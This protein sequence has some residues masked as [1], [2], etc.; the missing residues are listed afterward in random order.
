MFE[1]GISIDHLECNYKTKTLVN[2]IPGFLE[3]PKCIGIEGLNNVCF[4]RGGYG[5]PAAVDTLETVLALGVKKIVLVGMCGVFHE[6]IE[7]GDVIVPK[8]ILREEGTSHHY[9]GSGLLAQPDKNMLCSIT[10]FM[11]RN[12]TVYNERTVSTDAVY[13][14]TFRKEQ[15]WREVGV[16][17]VDME[18]S[19]VLAVCNYYKVP[20]VAILLASDKHP[21]D[22]TEREWQ[23]G[24]KGFKEKRIIFLDDIIDYVKY[25]A[26]TELIDG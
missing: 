6:R 7:V 12:F 10:K 15:S 3:T 9:I 25:L 1:I 18:A 14:Q 20:A 21:L 13:R 22:A 24:S 23:W 8:E 11:K 19:A 2:K 5:A 17:G 4:L 26:K 16:V